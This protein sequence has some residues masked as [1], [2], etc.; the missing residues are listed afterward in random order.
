[1]AIRFY[2]AL[3]FLGLVPALFAVGPLWPLLVIVLIPLTLVGSEMLWP[4][5]ASDRALGPPVTFRLLPLL[6]IPAQIAVIAWA[7][8]LVSRPGSDW[9]TLLSLVIAIGVVAGLFGMLAAHEA[10]HSHSR[11]DRFFGVAMLAAM[12]YPQFRVAHIHGHHRHAAC[13]RDPTTARR[14]ESYYGFVFRSV[15]TQFLTA[16]RHEEWRRRRLSRSLFANRVFRDMLLMLALYALVGAILGARAV[17]FFAGESILSIAA[18]S[19]FDY[20]AHYGLMRAPGERLGDRHSWNASH[21]VGNALLFNMGRHSDHHRHAA[22]PY[23]TLDAMADQPELPA[24]YAG[25]MLLALIPP[26][27]RKVMDRRLA[28]LNPA[29]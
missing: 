23:Q 10:I 18:L 22:G 11:L 17:L 15:T 29:A 2:G 9:L 25:S 3:I 28:A 7:A 13:A 12:S 8:W 1:V 19:L 5:L 6:Y 4:G 26:L 20:V 16:W 27:W 21:A 14:G 24:G